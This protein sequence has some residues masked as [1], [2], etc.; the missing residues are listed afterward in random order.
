MP[1]E[2]DKQETSM[3]II[4]R[5]TELF[6]RCGVASLPILNKTLLVL[7]YYIQKDSL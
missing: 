2:I 3:S 6:H 1:Y 4:I 7:L 5:V